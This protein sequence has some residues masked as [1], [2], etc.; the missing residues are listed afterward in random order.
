ML[1]QQ[2]MI[3]TRSLMALV[4]R[5]FKLHTMISLEF[6]VPWK[7]MVNSVFVF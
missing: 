1:V 2:P 3:A 6:N 7:R 5:L 4:I